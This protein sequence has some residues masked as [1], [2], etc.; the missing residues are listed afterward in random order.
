MARDGRVAVARFDNYHVEWFARDG[1][2]IVG[3]I[4]TYTPIEINAAEKRAFLERQVRPGSITVQNNPGG[5]AAPIASGPRK[6]IFTADTYDDK[7]MTWPARK[8]PFLANALSIDGAG[9]AWVLRTAPHNAPDLTYDVF[10]SAA[11]L[12]LTVTIPPKTKVVGFGAKSVYL[13][14]TD[15][16]DLQHLYRY[17]APQ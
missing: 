1:K 6:A 10:D 12:I 17:A 3:P 11:K 9:R 7:G 16:D 5:T 2:K 13:A 8:P 4:A 15:D 14:F